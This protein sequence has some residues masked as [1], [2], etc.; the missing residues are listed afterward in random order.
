MPASPS[1][2]EG[3]LV[4]AFVSLIGSD[5][6]LPLCMFLGVFTILLVSIEISSKSKS[7]MAACISV[8]SLIYFLILL[9]G[10]FVAA[11]VVLVPFSDTVTTAGHPW[12]YAFFGGFGGVFSFEGILSNTNITVF[13]RGVLTIADWIGRARDEAIA[14][15]VAEDAQRN[16]QAMIKNAKALAALPDAELNTHVTNA[17][18][19]NAVTQLEQE[20]NTA[21]ADP[22][23]YKGLKLAAEKPDY[24]KSILK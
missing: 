23:L 14:F 17:L 11:I 4:K 2:E 6:V 24:V 9:L 15:A 3:G 1:P 18:G 13:N 7:S 16:S 8:R 22:K 20:A 21:K 5:I 19:N 10:N 12:A